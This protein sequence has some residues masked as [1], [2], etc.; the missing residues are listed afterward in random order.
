MNLIAAASMPAQHRVPAFRTRATLAMILGG[1]VG[2]AGIGAASAAAP[3]DTV[4]SVVV[5][6]D[7]GSLMTDKG[8]QTLYRRIVA[9]ADKVC[10]QSP[11]SALVTAPVLQC[12]AQSIARAVQQ[13]NDSRLAAIHDA[14]SR[15]G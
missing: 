9:A 15:R 14:A 10:P 12:R 3:D 8:A 6:Y 4:P 7:P 1:I 5:K 13:I 11:G 2:A